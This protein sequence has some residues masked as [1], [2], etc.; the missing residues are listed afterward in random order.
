MTFTY[1]E[2]RVPAK[3]LY[4]AYV[5]DI[6]FSDRPPG[7]R[8]DDYRK[9]IMG[10]MRFVKDWLQEQAQAHGTSDGVCLCGGDVFHIKSPLSPANSNDLISEV[11]GL[12]KSFPNGGLYGIVGN[13]D[14]QFDNYSTLPNQPLGVLEAGHAY[15][16]LHRPTL[17]IPQEG[18]TV[19]V[20]PFH[21]SSDME[22]LEA[23]LKAGQEPRVGHYRVG[24]AHGMARPGGAQS[25]YG[26]PII[27]YD[28]M[29]GIDFDLMLW[30]HDHSY[31]KTQLVGECYH[32]HPG[33]LSRASLSSDE[34]DRDVL[35]VGFGFG[36]DL[37][38]SHKK[39]PCLPLEAAFRVADVGV[40]KVSNESAKAVGEEITTIGEFQLVD[41]LEVLEELCGE[42]QA[43]KSLVI[44]DLCE[45]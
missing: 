33:S 1:D 44:N 19:E 12:F 29:E 40:A 17:F 42:D 31:V 22:T 15:H 36:E 38:I 5:T 25:M 45:Y 14:L 43:L 21:Y 13:H 20:W 16:I 10:K 37:S 34:T 30:G 32:V 35:V 2:V 24:I 4:M 7:R 9:A 26:H 8:A 27:G 6:H 3:T 41:A 23:I 39:V 28:L 11:M 18:P